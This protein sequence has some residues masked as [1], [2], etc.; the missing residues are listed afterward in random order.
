LANSD[1]LSAGT[2]NAS[3]PR[4]QFR[5][6]G[7]SVALDC[8]RYAV[9]RDL[10]ELAVADRVFAQHYAEPWAVKVVSGSSIHARPSTDSD[11]VATL[12]AD[13]LFHVLDAGQNWAWGRGEAPGTTGYI[14]ASALG[15]P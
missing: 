13:D 7:P 2:T 4:R 11:V 8:G 14:A 10:A 3:P 9:R 1:D 12:G 15:L 5:L 6:T